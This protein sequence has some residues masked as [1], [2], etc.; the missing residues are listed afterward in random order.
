MGISN[1]SDKQVL[2]NE[3]MKQPN[4]IEVMQKIKC[5][6]KEYSIHIKS[7]KMYQKL[8]IDEKDEHI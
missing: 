2:T 3:I 6:R 4:L 7:G 1:K 5:R 8:W